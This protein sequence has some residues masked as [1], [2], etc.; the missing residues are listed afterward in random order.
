[1][2]KVTERKNPNAMAQLEALVDGILADMAEVGAEDLRGN[3][4]AGPRSGVHY[5]GQPRQ[6]SA[7]GEYSQEQTGGLKRMVSSGMLEPGAAYFGLEPENEAEREEALAQEFGAPR[8]NLVG[9]ANVRRTALD[10]RTQSRMKAAA[11]RRR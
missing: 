9:R 6:S 8:N 1:M 3:L 11:Q 10:P 4:S 5:A 2:L 7:P